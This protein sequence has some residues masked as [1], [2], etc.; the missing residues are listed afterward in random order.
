VSLTAELTCAFDNL[1]RDFFRNFYNEVKEEKR[2]M[3]VERG[4]GGRFGGAH[5]RKKI[6]QECRP[7]V[8][9]GGKK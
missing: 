2:E 7:S 1:I 8:K 6:G 9:V 5:E 4:L 3:R